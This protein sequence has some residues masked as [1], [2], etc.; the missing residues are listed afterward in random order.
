[1]VRVASSLLDG[2]GVLLILVDGPVEDVV[3][4]EALADEEITE[5]LAEVAVV[6]LIIEAE[7][8]SVV[9]VDGKL[10]GEAAAKNLGGSGH[11]LLHDTVVLLLLSSSLEAL[12]RE[13]AAAEIEHD[14][15]K[16]LHIITARL[17]N[18][19]MGVNR[20]I[21]GSAGQVLV[22]S[23]RNVEVGLGIS[24]LLGEA[25]INNVDLVATL[26]DTHEEVVGLDV[27]VDEGFSMDILD[28][29]D[30]L[31]SQKQDSLQRELA[32]AE[33]EEILQAGAEEVEDHGVV[34]T[35][36][37][38]PADEGN[39]NAT[40]EGLVDAGLI[41]KLGVLGLDA[42]KLDGNLFTGDDVSA[43]VNITE[44]ARADLATDPVLVANAEIL[45]FQLARCIV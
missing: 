33:V 4:L 1:M 25:E 13:R 8:T 34:I 36:G 21:T 37:A 9:E 5:D 7:G 18:A 27:A 28:A 20:G 14:V 2:L 45:I 24:V 10:V 44:R 16:R 41:L 39:A 11:L 19:K 43:E 30:E 23:V 38:E 42:L 29:G 31:I 35:L 6:G 3:V 40:G 12:P 17:L 15:A 32:V 26:A 22:L